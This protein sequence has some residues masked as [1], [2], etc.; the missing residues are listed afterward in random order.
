MLEKSCFRI[1]IFVLAGVH[2]DR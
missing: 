1:Y 2:R